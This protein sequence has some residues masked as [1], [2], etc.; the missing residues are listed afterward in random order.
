MESIRHTLKNAFEAVRKVVKPT[1]EERAEQQRNNRIQDNYAK[2][3][4]AMFGFEL[5]DFGP[6]VGSGRSLA[7]LYAVAY[8][9]PIQ[10]DLTKE[11]Q[12]QK[13]QELTNALK[14]DGVSEET[15]KNFMKGVIERA[16]QKPEFNWYGL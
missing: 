3:T 1:P 6:P 10:Y 9:P 12:T 11:Q 8:I 7:G 16:S 5:E 15:I 4:H 13:I 2:L 14:E